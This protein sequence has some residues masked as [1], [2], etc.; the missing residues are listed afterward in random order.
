MKNKKKKIERH[1][2]K[3]PNDFQEQKEAAVNY[4]RKKLY[5]YWEKFA[6][7]QQEKGKKCH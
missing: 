3:H 6:L 7:E 5:T 4:A 2:K 1:Q